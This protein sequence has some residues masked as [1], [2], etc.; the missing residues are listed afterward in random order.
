MTRTH[1]L[2][3]ALL[4]LGACGGGDNDDSAGTPAPTPPTTGGSSA[5]PDFNAYVVSVV[6]AANANTA[7]PV[8]VDAL[9]FTFNEDAGGTFDALVN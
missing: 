1:V 8:D 3:A 6:N 7:E 4:V 2:M 9:S 5:P